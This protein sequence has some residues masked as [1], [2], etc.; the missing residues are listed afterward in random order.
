MPP[1]PLP[2]RN[3][4]SPILL[5]ALVYPGLGQYRTGRRTIGLLYAAGFTLALA[6]FLMFF[7]RYYQDVLHFVESWWSGD[8]QPDEGTPSA[9]Q[10]LM[11][12]IYLLI[13]YLANVYD[14]AWNLYR[15]HPTTPEATPPK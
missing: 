3:G 9:R 8:Y 4:P 6:I 5:S 14:V 10:L 15:P 12:G 1:P 11:P 2:Q 7:V 13:V